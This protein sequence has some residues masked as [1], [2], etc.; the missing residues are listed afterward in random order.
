MVSGYWMGVSCGWMGVVAGRWTV[1][2]VNTFFS[3][4]MS[5]RLRLVPCGPITMPPI[6][7]ILPPYAGGSGSVLPPR[8]LLVTASPDVAPG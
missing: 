5:L 1:L 8:S 6:G 2:G 7:V 3:L 4:L